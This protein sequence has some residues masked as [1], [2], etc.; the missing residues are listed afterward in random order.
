MRTQ[1]RPIILITLGSPRPT[2]KLSKR[3]AQ[4]PLLGGVTLLAASIG[5]VFHIKP[6]L[7]CRLLALF[8]PD[9]PGS[10]RLFLRVKRTSQLRA[11][12]V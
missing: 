12:N 1:A 10:R 8:G 3:P 11:P 9:R 6:N 7:R 5:S 4:F 2:P